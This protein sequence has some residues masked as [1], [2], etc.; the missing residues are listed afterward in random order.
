MKLLSEDKALMR[1][2][3]LRS[4][5]ALGLIVVVVAF[6]ANI[7]GSYSNLAELKAADSM[8]N[9]IALAGLFYAA[10]SLMFCIISKPFWFP[11]KAE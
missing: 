4:N 9:N 7:T 6:A 10:G 1:R 8:Y 11:A 3:L 2:R 5:V